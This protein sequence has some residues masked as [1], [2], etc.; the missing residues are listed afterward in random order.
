MIRIV[1]E[2]NKGNSEGL[3]AIKEAPKPQPKKR[4][5]KEKKL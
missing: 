5:R 4:T 1:R 3:K 2:G